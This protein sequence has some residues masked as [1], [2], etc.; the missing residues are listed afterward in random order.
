MSTVDVIL[1]VRKDVRFRLVGDE[2]IVLRQSLGEVL[3]LNRVAGRI[4][5]LANGASSVDEWIRVLGGE[6]DVD[7]TTLARDVRAFAA[8]LLEEGVLE[9]AREGAVDPRGAT[10]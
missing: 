10:P 3:V 7:S 2:A 4:L 9:I 8:Q 1:S 5:Q 6:F